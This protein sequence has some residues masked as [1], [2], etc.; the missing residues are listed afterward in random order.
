M[1]GVMHNNSYFGVF[2]D[3]G[4]YGKTR[5]LSF[6]F[7]MQENDVYVRWYFYTFISSFSTYLGWQSASKDNLAR[8]H[9]MADS[10]ICL[11]IQYEL[12]LESVERVISLI[13]E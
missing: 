11:P 9:K 6:H 2:L 12:D 7:G 10:V 5:E 8:T 4:V 1:P 13:K 3:V